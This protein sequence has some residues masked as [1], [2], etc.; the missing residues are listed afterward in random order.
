MDVIKQ[1]PVKDRLTN[2]QYEINCKQKQLNYENDKWIRDFGL[3]ASN[4]AVAK[5]QV[6]KALHT[7]HELLT[8]SCDVLPVA[9]AIRLRDFQSRANNVTQ[10]ARITDGECYDIMNFAYKFKRKQMVQRKRI[11]R[12]IK[13][14]RTNTQTSSQT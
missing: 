2:K 13:A 11:V 14:L 10:L 7:A 4:F 5:L 9:D 8:E 1:K 3:N 6:L 12:K